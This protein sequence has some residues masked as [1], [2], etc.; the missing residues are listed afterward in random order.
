MDAARNDVLHHRAD[1]WVFAWCSLTQRARRWQAELD[2]ALHPHALVAGEFLVLWR[3]EHACP[4][5]ISQIELARELNISAAQICGIVEQLQCR[6]WLQTARP[7]TD[8]RRLYCSLTS[9]G[10]IVLEALLAELIPLF[11]RCL[12]DDRSIAPPRGHVHPQ[13]EAA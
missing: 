5:G 2:A 1:D 6:D 11:E 10:A 13:E 9:S 4:P 8:R 12:R 7:A 3:T